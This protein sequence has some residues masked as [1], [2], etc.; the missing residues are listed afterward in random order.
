GDVANGI[1]TDGDGTRDTPVPVYS[2]CSAT[3]TKTVVATE[4]IPPDVS[5]IEP[6]N[7][8][9][10]GLNFTASGHAGFAPGDL[11]T[12]TVKVYAG[13]GTGGA[14][15]YTQDVTRSGSNWGPVTV[16]LPSS[17]PD[18]DYTVQAVQ[19]DNSGNV[20]TSVP[21]QVTLDRVA[22]TVAVTSP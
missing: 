14:V 4:T 8:T 7:A 16:T 11:N 9:A 10:V 20:G 15:V 18:G 1:D 22:P 17:L 19:V 21:H 12:V 3:M 13:V 2:D 6:A 5:L